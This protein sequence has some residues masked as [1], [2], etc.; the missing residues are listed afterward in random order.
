MADIQ[1]VVRIVRAVPLGRVVTYGDV[2][3]VVYGHRQASRAVG[4]QI[5]SEANK[6]PEFPW[7]RV[8]FEGLRPKDGA[9][10][11]LK[12]E[13]VSLSGGKAISPEYRHKLQ[14][15]SEQ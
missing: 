3:E 7:W 1:R 14:P 11:K 5:R 4:Q 6:D 9:Q 13:G 15:V 10:E 12:K 8:C 2:S